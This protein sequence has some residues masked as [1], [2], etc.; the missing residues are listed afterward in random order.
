MGFRVVRGRGITPD[1][2]ADRSPVIV[3]N[4]RA[5]AELWPNEDALGQQ[6]T[7]GLPRPDNPPATVV[8]IVANVRSAAGAP[9]RNLD[10][11]YPYAQYPVDALYYVLR[12]SVPPESLTEVVRR[13]IQETEPSIAV[14]TIKPLSQ[15][16]DESLWLQRLWSRL[17][18]VFA[19]IALVLA[20]VGLYGV[21]AYLVLQRSREMVIRMSVGATGGQIATLLL[22]GMLRLVASGIAIGVAAS[23]AVSPLIGALLF[24]VSPTSARTYLLVASTVAAAAFLACCPP[25]YRASRFSP[26]SVLKEE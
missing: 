17:L 5:A 13:T 20:A 11:Y 7:W 10:L 8:G 19:T 15:W 22:G 26:M 16:I 2:I 18:A 24:E 4:E 3:I 1:D 6:I 14:A 12:T 23:L 25:I 9:D 21:V